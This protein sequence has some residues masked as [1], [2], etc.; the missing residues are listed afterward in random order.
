MRNYMKDQILLINDLAG[1]GK[2]ALSAMLPVMTHAGL[3]L[4]N[5]PTALVSN[6]LDYGKFE[7]LET[8]EYMRKTMKVWAE[9]GFSFDAVC[10]GFIA[11]KE[12]VKLISGYLRQQKKKGTWIFVDP[13][14]GDEGKLYN[15]IEEKTVGYMRDLC[16]LADV[17]VPNLTEA[18]FLAGMCQGK[19]VITQGEGREI[20][21]KLRKLG[22]KSIVITSVK[23][24]AGDFV[25]IYDHQTDTVSE[26]PF[27]QIPV[28][29]P[30]TGDIFSAILASQVLNGTALEKAAQRAMSAV[31]QLIAINHETVDKFKGIPIEKNLE[32][33]NFESSED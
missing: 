29:F 26:L 16:S 19:E 20:L 11:S 7:I 33:L 14:M 10:T 30:G 1:Y 13:I 28:R 17:I 9:L 2:V 31:R 8:T 32:V 12:Q 27:E 4:Y 24:E 21:K 15:G 25:L 5:L 3:N 6:T 18:S 23:T 22:A